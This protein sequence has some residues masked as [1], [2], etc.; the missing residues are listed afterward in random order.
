MTA[1]PET[2]RSVMLGRS[3]RQVENLSGTMIGNGKTL[4][5]SFDCEAFGGQTQECGFEVQPLMLLH[6]N[7]TKLR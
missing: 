2:M 1:E 5:S 3:A 6:S 4:T 7:G